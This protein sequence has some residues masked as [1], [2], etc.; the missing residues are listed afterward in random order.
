MVILTFEEQQQNTS[1]LKQLFCISL[2]VK[3][4]IGRVFE[5]VSLVNECSGEWR[6]WKS[7]GKWGLKSG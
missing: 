3:T 1:T 4:D 6:Y 7:V 2:T 5:T